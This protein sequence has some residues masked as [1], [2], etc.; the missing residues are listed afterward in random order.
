MSVY[1]DVLTS[2]ISLA[3]Q[4]DLY[5]HIVIGPMPP[6]NGIS[7]AWATGNLNTFLNKKAAVVMSAVLNCKNSDQEI[8]SDTLG[9]IHTFLNMR[10]NSIPNPTIFKSQILKL[11][12][13][14]HIWGVRKTING[15]MV[16]A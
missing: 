6:K 15:F 16:R 8:A 13:R 5:S 7:I 3:K 10:K 4:A 11:Q 2:V 12:A 1:D 14:L 9:K